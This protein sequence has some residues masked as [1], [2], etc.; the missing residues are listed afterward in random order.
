MTDNRGHATSAPPP[1]DSFG[2]PSRR[3]N[4]LTTSALRN[5]GNP[6]RGR[7]APLRQAFRAGPTGD[8]GR[9]RAAG[10]RGLVRPVRMG[11][12]FLDMPPCARP[13]FPA[14]VVLVTPKNL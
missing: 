4:V 2:D 5:R 13:A 8:E 10:G 11:W 6:F 7:H 14:S 9:G 1:V 3:Q 12:T